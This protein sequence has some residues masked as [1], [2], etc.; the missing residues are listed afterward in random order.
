MEKAQCCEESALHK[1]ERKRAFS[2]EN[3]PTKF[4]DMVNFLCYFT[5]IMKY[6][7]FLSRLV[8]F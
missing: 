1:D 7:D 3:T 4:F 6:D 5:P 2:W 8:L